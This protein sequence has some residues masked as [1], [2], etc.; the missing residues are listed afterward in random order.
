[1]DKIEDTHSQK[2]I[3]GQYEEEKR[4]RKAEDEKYEFKEVSK[5]TPVVRLGTFG[6]R[7]RK[8]DSDN[9]E[10]KEDP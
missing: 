10:K 1:M 6:N 8:P 2:S 7:K 9:N 3:R 4:K 5:D